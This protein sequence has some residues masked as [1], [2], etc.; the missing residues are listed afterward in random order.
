MCIRDSPTA[1][2]DIVP[3]AFPDDPSTAVILVLN[4]PLASA[5][6]PVISVLLAFPV[7]TIPILVSFVVILAARLAEVDVNE[8]EIE[9]AVSDLINVALTP[10]DPDIPA[11]VK[12][13]INV[14]LSPKDPD[15]EVE[16]IPP[17]DPEIESELRDLIKAALGPKEP[18]IDPDI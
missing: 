5:K 4:E 2:P 6:E 18:E 13:L 12:D 9:V 7:D 16:V 11:P 8:P 17:N 14:A 1:D 15:T 10:K 3:A